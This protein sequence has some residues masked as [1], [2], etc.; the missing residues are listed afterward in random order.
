MEVVEL[1][2]AGVFDER[3]QERVGFFIRQPRLFGLD[4][5]VEKLLNDFEHLSAGDRMGNDRGVDRI[6]K[7]WETHVGRFLWAV[8]TRLVV[9]Y[10]YETHVP[11]LH[12][13]LI[14]DFNAGDLVFRSLVQGV[15]SD[16]KV[17]EARFAVVLGDV[18]GAQQSTS[19]GSP[20]IVQ[21]H[22]PIEPAHDLVSVIEGRLKFVVG[23][24]VFENEEF[25]EFAR[26]VNREG[27]LFQRAEGATEF[28]LFVGV[29]VLSAKEQ[30]RI[31]IPE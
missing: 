19:I 6:G 13:E 30:D 12:V 26:A 4:D 28:D 23:P 1:R 17:A 29:D 9:L 3:L 18:H 10:V 11:A 24:T 31:F 8:W 16:R 7:V 20:R 22:V 15:V 25:G 27:M 21:V 2:L 14:R 5:A